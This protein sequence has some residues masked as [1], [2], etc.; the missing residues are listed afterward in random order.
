MRNMA[1]L[2][3]GAELERNAT[4]LEHTLILAGDVAPA[5]SVWQGWPSNMIR[6][7]DLNSKLT[8][9]SRSNLLGSVTRLDL[10]QFGHHDDLPSVQ[11]H[12]NSLSS[13]GLTEGMIAHEVETLK[14]VQ[15]GQL[16]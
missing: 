9:A 1:R 11:N 10:T 7:N 5:G 3:A 4:M 2:L 8:V 16:F 12:Y 15:K 13:F 6:G 14:S